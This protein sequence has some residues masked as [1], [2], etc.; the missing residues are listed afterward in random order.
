[1]SRGFT[2]A[3]AS[4]KGGTGKTTIATNLACSIARTGRAVQ[5]LDCDVEEP[6]G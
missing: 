1:M 2:I 5:Y 4:G 6:N 3:V